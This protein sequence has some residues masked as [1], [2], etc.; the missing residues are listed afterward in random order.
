M[1]GLPLFTVAV[2]LAVAG[3]WIIYT[4]VFLVISR[5]WHLADEQ[6]IPA[7]SG[8]EGQNQ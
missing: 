8:S 4:L 6:P 7:E 5:N 1:F 2:L 3:F